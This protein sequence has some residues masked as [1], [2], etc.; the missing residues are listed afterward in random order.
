MAK[1]IHKKQ[2]FPSSTR[3]KSGAFGLVVVIFF[4]ILEKGF[5]WTN[6]YYA[7]QTT[8]FHQSP[9]TFKRPE[10]INIMFALCGNSRGFFAEF[11]VALKSVL[12]N[13]PHNRDA[14]V[15]L[16]ANQEAYDYLPTV[17]NDIKVDGIEWWSN[18]TIIP[19]NVEPQLGRWAQMLKSGTGLRADGRH[20]F[21]TYFR[22][23]ANQILPTNVEYVLYF[24]TDVVVLANLNHLF[25]NLQDD[26]QSMKERPMFIMAAECA[27][28][29]L[30]NIQKLDKFWEHVH[31][32]NWTKQ[33]LRML[34]QSMVVEVG[35]QHPGTVK[36]LSAPWD[37]TALKHWNQFVSV[38]HQFMNFNESTKIQT[39]VRT[40][41]VTKLTKFRPE[42][43]I[44][45]YNGGGSNS[46]S[47]YNSESVQSLQHGFGLPAIFFWDL[48]WTW[49]AFMGK[50]VGGPANTG[51][52]I[53]GWSNASVI[54]HRPTKT[55]QR[56]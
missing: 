22:L 1:H 33:T 50:S 11:K 5:Q 26:L 19:Y 38:T 27:G 21:G 24:D 3:L 13:A 51:V 17:W 53:Q 31:S 7:A 18:I 10:P 49:V 4:V 43:G 35:Q 45:H 29:M 2:S 55:I 23:F 9:S 30:I 34:D 15:H 48:P 20:T 28:V 8:E 56:S 36:L 12:L 54:L 16:L 46:D 25:Q 41:N 14:H 39:K 52:R 44:F 32:F 40:E 6:T 42:A 37:L 47:Y